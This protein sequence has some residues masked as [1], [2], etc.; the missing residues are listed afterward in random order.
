MPTHSEGIRP[1]VANSPGAILRAAVVAQNGA[2]CAIRPRG[3]FS[4]V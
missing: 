3:S 4:D 1:G 2:V